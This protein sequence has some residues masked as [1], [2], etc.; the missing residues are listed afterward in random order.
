MASNSGFGGSNYTLAQYTENIPD[1]Y[2]IVTSILTLHPV[3]PGDHGNYI[4]IATNSE[5]ETNASVEITVF[6][7]K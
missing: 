1:G 2:I 5:G 6:C 7:E 3:I 4:C